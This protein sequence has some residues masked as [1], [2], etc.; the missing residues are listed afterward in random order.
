M[1]LTGAAQMPI[2]KRYYISDIPGLGWL[3][4]FY[5]T[6]KIHYLFGAVLIFL[7][8]YLVTVFVLARKRDFQLTPS[9]LLRSGLYA[10]VMAT[11]VCR[12]VKNLPFVTLDPLAVMLIDWTHLG[13]AILLGIT[14]LYAFFR[15]RLPYMAELP[16]ISRR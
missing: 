10:A 9:G 6:N 2:F 16:R 11:G 4:D 8:L 14:A 15:G 5:L 7:A 1:A 3:A 13:F 12:V